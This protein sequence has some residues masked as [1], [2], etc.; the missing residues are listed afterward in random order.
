MTICHILGEQDMRCTMRMSKKGI[1][2]SHEDQSIRGTKNRAWKAQRR[3]KIKITVK[4]IKN[5][6]K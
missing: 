2:L 3:N 6:L 5:H 1:L 4:F